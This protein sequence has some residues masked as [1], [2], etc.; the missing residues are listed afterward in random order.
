VSERPE[1]TA[2]RGVLAVASLAAVST[3]SLR[4]RAGGGWPG[5]AP[6]P[7]EQGRGLGPRERQQREGVRIAA[8]RAASEDMGELG[9]A[10]GRGRP[11]AAAQPMDC[12]EPPCAS[13]LGDGYSVTRL[14]LPLVDAGTTRLPLGDDASGSVTLPFAFPF[15]G[16]SYTELFV[17]SDGNLTF[18]RPIALPSRNVGRLVGVRR[19]SHRCSR[20]STLERRQRRDAGRGRPLPG[21]LGLGAPVR[22]DRQEHVP[23]AALHRWAHRVPV[24]HRAIRQQSTRAPRASHR[25]PGETGLTGIDLSAAAGQSGTGALGKDSARKTRST[26]GRGQALLREPSRRLSAAHHLH[27]TDGS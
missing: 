11:R 17:N 27:E 22:Q 14:A 19:G 18:A 10:A 8:S 21:E 23:G 20:T 3:T 4:A 13:R 1:P 12:R 16:R 6:T 26:R 15:F 5:V 24:R 9:R 7:R 2:V 25:A